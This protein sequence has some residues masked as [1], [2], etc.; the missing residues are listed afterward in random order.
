MK[1]RKVSL[2][3][4]GIVFFIV[5]LIFFII[6]LF[7]KPTDY[8]VEFIDIILMFPLVFKVIVY[9]LFDALARLVGPV[10]MVIGGILILIGKKKRK[11]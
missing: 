5:G 8:T 3:K 6:S 9:G 1:K 4:V 10:F 7:H 2:V 11:E